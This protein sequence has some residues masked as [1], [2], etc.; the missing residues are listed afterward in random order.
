MSPSSQLPVAIVGGGIT[1]LAAAHALARRGIPFRLFE[2][3][4]RTG[5]SVRTERDD[6]G[7]LIEAGPNSLQLTPGVAQLVD[8]LGLRP[9]LQT[10]D[11][12]AKKRFIVRRGCLVAL[13][14]SPPALLASSAFS[15]P[16]KLRLLRELFQQPRQRPSD[17]DLATFIRDH[18]GDEW[19]DYALSPFISG[20]YAGD[21][22]QLSARHAFP[23][24]WR[25]EQ[26]CG[27]LL[28]GQLAS[29]R[30]KRRLG[31]PRGPT[32]IVSF[33]DGLATLTEALAAQL[34]AGAVELEASV[35]TLTPG[36]PWQLIWRRGGETHRE[37]FSAVALAAPAGAIAQLH[38][39]TA[40]ER[41]LAALT[42]LS[43]PPVS[44]LFLGFRRDD[45]AHPLDGFGLLAPPCETQPMLGV[46]FSSSLFPARA[47]A[48][49]AALTVIVGG[50]LHPD[51]TL[52]PT[53]AL[54]DRLQPAL[55]RLL[56][57]ATA[58]VFIRR[59]DWAHAIPQYNLGHER[60][61][62]TIAACER[63]FPNLFIGGP[64]RDGISLPQCLI[65]GQ[66]LA[67]RL[68]P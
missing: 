61:L 1:G 44:S 18:L 17:V 13:P 27:S 38:F 35:E 51:I 5:G 23:T 33:A 54:L 29:A 43:Y 59:H 21:A 28:R 22:T 40:G 14:S 41:P 55:A 36:P 65:A 52:L 12:A 2:A 3:T 20:I 68:R 39:G 4:D 42:D 32:P 34:P 67:T 63:T 30:T 66:T 64:V 45:I 10:A 47:P 16:A 62:E 48:G 25:L 49:H 60:F 6:A 9:K 31:E 24:L 58:P 46:L 15:L 53:P 8:A 7:W 37:T 57:V 11:P 26:E 56:G 19:V 50:A